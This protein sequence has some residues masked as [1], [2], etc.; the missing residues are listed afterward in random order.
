MR[1]IAVHPQK[2]NEIKDAFPGITSTPISSLHFG[3]SENG[4]N[5]RYVV[6]LNT[7]IASF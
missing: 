4:K 5:K 6:I 7:S 3:A 2:I 1:A